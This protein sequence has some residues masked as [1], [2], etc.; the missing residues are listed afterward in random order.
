[1]PVQQRQ[2][3]AADF[4]PAYELV[5][6]NGNIGNP[7]IDLTAAGKFKFELLQG[8]IGSRGHMFRFPDQTVINHS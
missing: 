8:G 1:M 3:Q 4:D 6:K 7:L 2:R 5:H